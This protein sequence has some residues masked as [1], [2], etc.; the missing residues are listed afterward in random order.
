MPKSPRASLTTSQNLSSLQKQQ[1]TAHYHQQAALD[2]SYQLKDLGDWARVTFNLS[3]TPSRSTIYRVLNQDSTPAASEPSSS[4]RRF[5]SKAEELDRL[6]AEWVE[7]KQ[8]RSIMINGHLIKQ[9]GQIFQDRLNSTLP[10]DQKLSL[11]FS[12]GWLAKFCNRHSFKQQVAHGESG[13][14]QKEDIDKEMPALKQLLQQYQPQDIFNADETGLF[15]NSPPNRTIGS[16]SVAGLKKDKTRFSIL[17][18]CNSTGTEKL[19][20]LFI[21]HY[22]QPRPF[23][24]QTPDQLGIQYY[25]NKTAW[26]TSTIFTSW[27][28]S[29]DYII[30]KTPGRHIL[31]LLDNFS[32]HGT[33]E[34]PL[35]NLQNISIHFLPPNSTSKIQPLDA[36]IIA[37]FKKQYRARQYQMALLE[38]E[39]GNTDI[40]KVDILTAMRMCQRIW[41]GLSMD[42][43]RNCWRHTGLVEWDG[44]VQCNAEE[45]ELDK[46]LGESL[47]KLT[48]V[49]IQDV[50]EP[51]EEEQSGF[52]EAEDSLDITTPPRS[53]SARAEEPAI[54]TMPAEEQLKVLQ[55]AQEILSAQGFLTKPVL[56]AFKSCTLQ[57]NSE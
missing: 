4:T 40:Y 48:E 20:P 31:L 33:A 41:A 37:A 5:A 49:T 24:K 1:L 35:T 28:T 57:I 26:M 54:V 8:S 10:Q 46:E 44:E 50:I 2:P 3:Y 43:I 45:G 25:N 42:T 34:N 19:E 36:G 14:V 9:Q 39:L 32:G 30:G 21:G 52:E 27:L 47:R 55:A 7:D 22:Q 29:L 53:P 15:Y 6:L 16:S 17:F 56:D 18:A 51:P 11:K 23:K 12:N 38:A 13:S